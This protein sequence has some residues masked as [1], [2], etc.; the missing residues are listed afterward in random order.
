MLSLPIPQ[1]QKDLKVSIKYYPRSLLCK[2]KE[3]IFQVGEY[4][5]LN[6]IKAKIVENVPKEQAED[7]PFVAKIKNK[8]VIELL[9][10]EKFMKTY[11]ERG[12][13]I[14]AYERI[15]LPENA[16][17]SHFLLEVKIY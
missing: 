6:E 14:V 3:F 4:A 10:K 8:S 1:A 15:A 9:D 2:P 11:I 12:D 7:H 5:T 13:E 16:G 17:S